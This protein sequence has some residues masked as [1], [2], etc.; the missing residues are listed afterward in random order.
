MNKE[1]VLNASSFGVEK[2]ISE[3]IE[4]V[5]VPMVEMLKGF[6]SA[7][8]GIIEEAEQ[9]I[10]PKV[11][12][13]A[14]RVRLDISKVRIQTE[15]TRKSQKAEY[16]R[17]G[18]A[19]DGVANILKFAVMEK[20][21]KLKEIEMH[22][23]LIKAEKKAVIQAD[24]ETEL[25]KYDAE[26][27]GIDLADMPD[28]VWDKFLEGYKLAH[29]KIIE[30]EMKAE[31][32]RILA[33][34]SEAERI[35]KV[36]AENERLKKEAD[37]RDRLQTIEDKKQ[38]KIQ[39]DLEKKLQDEHEERE[40]VE[41]IELEKRAKEAE[42][43]EKKEAIERKKR[44]AIQ[45][46]HEKKLQDERDKAIKLER[47]IAEK[48]AS[49]ERATAEKEEKEKALRLAP[50]KEKLLQLASTIQ[51]IEIPIVKNKEAQYILKQARERLEKTY[52]DLIE[53]AKKI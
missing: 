16:L 43:R 1:L 38:A 19:I 17:A 2:N 13:D 52:I 14:K 44:E 27:E 47:E 18:N 22:F 7:Y 36:E 33:E 51:D 12:N 4:A 24:R 8:N 28:N 21:E 40:K 15:K 20:E 6:E 53:Q 50:D 37:E 5:F 9:E 25:L 35:A 32:A 46:E 49:E 3:Q 30:S 45:A 31:E 11:V 29:E 41:K 34:K 10:S 26:V 23:E 39:A 42:E 48:K